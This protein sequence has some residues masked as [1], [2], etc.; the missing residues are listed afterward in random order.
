MSLGCL[1][2]VHGVVEHVRDGL[3]VQVVLH[4]ELELL[5]HLG[6]N[7]LLPA[8]ELDF[9]SDLRPQLADSLCHPVLGLYGQRVQVLLLGGSKAFLAW[10]SLIP[11]DWPSCLKLRCTFLFVI[12]WYCL[13]QI[14]ASLR[15]SKRWSLKYRRMA[16]SSSNSKAIV[17]ALGRV[18]ATLS[19]RSASS[20]S[21]VAL[22]AR[23]HSRVVLGKSLSV[24]WRCCDSKSV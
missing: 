15:D 17:L 6:Q 23:K 9:V 22:Y 3:V 10:F 8:G 12:A 18:P 1:Q 21:G 14:K 24:L 5:L 19:C 20:Q 4:R 2:L 11:H 7:E 16:Y 13:W